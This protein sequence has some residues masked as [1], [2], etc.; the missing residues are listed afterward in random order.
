MMSFNKTLRALLTIETV[1]AVALTVLY[2]G[3]PIK[4]DYLRIYE[5]SGALAGALITTYGLYQMKD[6][7]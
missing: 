6:F 1:L 4:A 3:F 5:L 7:A 2:L